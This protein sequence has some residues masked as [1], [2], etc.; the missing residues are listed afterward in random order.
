MKPATSQNEPRVSGSY[1]TADKNAEWN[2]LS[3]LG[4]FEKPFFTPR[5]T[6]FTLDEAATRNVPRRIPSQDDEAWW[7]HLFP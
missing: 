6:R 4:W 3:R 1:K 7:L 5:I 2:S